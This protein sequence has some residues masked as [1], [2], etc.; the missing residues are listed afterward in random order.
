MNK[1]KRDESRE[2]KNNGQVTRTKYNATLNYTE[3][4]N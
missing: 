4:I 3:Q 1:K 2:Q